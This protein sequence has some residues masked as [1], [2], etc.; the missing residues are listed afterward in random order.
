M[1][2]L[3]PA[4]PRSVCA[5]IVG[6][7]PDGAPPPPLQA[8]EAEG[9]A[10]DEVVV[11]AHLGGVRAALRKALSGDS[12]WIWILDSSVRPDPAALERLL[13]VLD[14]LGELPSPVLLASKV[15]TAAGELDA[16]S[17]PVPD[18]LRRDVAVAA[19]RRR[20]V[21]LR[22]ASRGSLLVHRRGFEARGLPRAAPPF[23]DDRAWTARL[24]K[25]E[26]G[27]LVPASVAV[28]V[29]IRGR[30]E[31]PRARRE[32]TSGLR[33]VLGGA[34]EPKEAP[35]FAFR[36]TEQAVAAVY[37]RLRAL[38]RRAGAGAHRGRRE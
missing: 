12:A 1:T 38:T 20:L 37:S 9:L 24:L 23:Y 28:R 36:L 11:A 35:W 29:P 18:V 4:R 8:L 27:L 10:P 15:V 6:P 3:R 14:D 19:V 21:A 2:S 34:L 5:V 16:R 26:I 25:D 22:V 33:L 7:I 17:A 30:D 31:S 13:G 32:L